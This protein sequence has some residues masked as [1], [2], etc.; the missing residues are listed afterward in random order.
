MPQKYHG[1]DYD[2][3]YDDYDPQDYEEVAAVPRTSSSGGGAGADQSTPTACFR[4]LT[5]RDC[6]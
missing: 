2:D 6:L 3:G 1:D 4:R 5:E